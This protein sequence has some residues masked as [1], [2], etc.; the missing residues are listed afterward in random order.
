MKILNVFLENFKEFLKAR[1][2]LSDE[3]KRIYFAR[4]QKVLNNQKHEINSIDDIDETSIVKDLKEAKRN[5]NYISQTKNGFKLL[6]RSNDE[7]FFNN[8]IEKLQ[9]N[10]PKQRKKREEELKLK[11]VNIRINAVRNKK[12]KLAF[13]FEQITGLRI[14]EIASLTKNDIEFCEDGRIKVHVRNGKGG[15]ARKFKALKDKYVYDELKKLVEQTKKDK[16]FYCK[17]YMQDKAQQLKF[18]THDQRKVFSQIVY[19]NSSKNAEETIEM[20]QKVLGHE[21][22]TKTYLKY[23]NRNIDFTGTKYDFELTKNLT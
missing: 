3:T 7:F 12:M 18:H 19:Y 2:G 20:L 13:R 10:A 6:Y 14:D 4:V 15:K 16:I 1:D 21:P 5:K 22:N 23:I 17:K 9:D 8:D 11:N